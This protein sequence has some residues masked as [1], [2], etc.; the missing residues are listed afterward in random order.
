SSQADGTTARHVQVTMTADAPLLF[1][2][3]L[4]LG[5]Q[6]TTPVGA[7]ATAG[8]SS[9][10]CVACGIEPFAILPVDPSDTQNFGFVAGSYYT[11][12][13]QCTASPPA[14]PAPQP[15]M[16]NLVSY[17]LI[18]HYDAGNTLDDES[19]QLYIA[20]ANGLLAAP[21]SDVTAAG[22]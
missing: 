21:T 11:F 9:P 6:R 2:S 5:Q 16:G 8:V 20:G 22:L 10:V 1:W 17:L 18:D 4:S 12:G 15:L 3:L 7:I 13:Y 14:N 19:Q